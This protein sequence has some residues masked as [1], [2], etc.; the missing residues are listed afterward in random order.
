MDFTGACRTPSCC[1]DCRG[2]NTTDTLPC[3]Q[4]GRERY[5]FP[6]AAGPESFPGTGTSSKIGPPWHK[7]ESVEKLDT[8]RGEIPLPMPVPARA[9]CADMQ[10][11]NGRRSQ[12]LHGD[13][14]SAWHPGILSYAEAELVAIDAQLR[15]IEQLRAAIDAFQDQEGA[16]GKK[17][18]KGQLPR[19]QEDWSEETGT[20]V[21]S[22]GATKASSARDS[23]RRHYL[24]HKM[25]K[26][27]DM[28]EDTDVI[29]TPRS[30]GEVASNRVAGSMD[31]SFQQQ[32]QQQQRLQNRKQHQRPQ[33]QRDGCFGWCWRS[34]EPR[35]GHRAF[36]PTCF[37]VLLGS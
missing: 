7:D 22:A 13:G 31:P 36:L 35:C 34:R 11:S 17:A 18:P 1:R 23:A 16:H 37:T 28:A 9:A 27:A 4:Q 25:T 32:Q 6:D 19:V 21:S 2:S 26:E 5:A 3:L 8:V 29:A 33:P 30:L 12:T 10:A 14:F 20:V 15:R 24:E